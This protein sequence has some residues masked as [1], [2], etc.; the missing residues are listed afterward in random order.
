LRA[1]VKNG[2]Q[3]Q[4]INATFCI[5]PAELTAN[6]LGQLLPARSVVQLTECEKITNSSAKSLLLL[7]LLLLGAA[8]DG[9][10]GTS[11][12]DEYFASASCN[13][14]GTNETFP[15]TSTTTD[16][17]VCA[18]S[19][20]RADLKTAMN[21]KWA[22]VPARS[23]DDLMRAVTYA[24][25]LVGVNGANYYWQYYTGGILSCTTAATRRDWMVNRE[26]RVCV[27]VY[28][29]PRLFTCAASCLRHMP[30]PSAVDM[31]RKD[32]SRTLLQSSNL[33][34]SP[35]CN[36]Y[37]ALLQRSSRLIALLTHTANKLGNQGSC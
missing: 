4:C 13:G 3:L 21:L 24:P 6:Q 29:N 22:K 27:S 30:K 28:L 8:E 15:Y 11:T 34:S 33:L 1:K 18:F 19:A 9:C 25:T 10:Q 12:L 26:S 16:S 5:Q 2:T 32:G 37:I 35:S 23:N 31:Q 7:L 20:E 36:K 17:N 14:Q